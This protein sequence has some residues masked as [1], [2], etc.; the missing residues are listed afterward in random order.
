[1]CNCASCKHTDSFHRAGFGAWP[2]GDPAGKRASERAYAAHVAHS[3]VGV[4]KTVQFTPNQPPKYPAWL[5]TR[6]ADPHAHYHFPGERYRYGMG[7]ALPAQDTVEGYVRSFLEANHLTQDTALP[8]EVSA[9][10]VAR[11]IAMARELRQ[12]A[13]QELRKAA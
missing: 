8:D 5:G 2:K 11:L 7:E 4:S 1:M 6:Y 3:W 13:R 9:K 12:Q 10:P